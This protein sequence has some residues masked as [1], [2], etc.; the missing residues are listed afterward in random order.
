MA[1][2]TAHRE[3]WG[4][5]GAKRS[6]IKRRAEYR[7]ACQERRKTMARN[8]APA[9]FPPIREWPVHV[10]NISPRELRLWCQLNTTQFH[11]QV[12]KTRGAPALLGPILE[13]IG[14]MIGATKER[15]AWWLE[16]DAQ[17]QGARNDL[18]GKAAIVASEDWHRRLVLPEGGGDQV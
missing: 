17:R 2:M 1:A 5:A 13:D 8:Y 18:I 6:C 3:E 9:E 15:L 11:Q 10:P 12:D 16:L 7:N 4:V 14:K